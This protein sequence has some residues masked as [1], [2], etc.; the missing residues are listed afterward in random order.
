M[1]EIFPTGELGDKWLLCVKAIFKY[2]PIRGSIE[3]PN[4]QNWDQNQMWTLDDLEILSNRVNSFS[5]LVRRLQKY[6]RHVLVTPINHGF[7]GCETGESI[8]VLAILE[9]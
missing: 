3:I 7:E 5:T 2:E 1:K 6:C 4:L 9:Q 8:C